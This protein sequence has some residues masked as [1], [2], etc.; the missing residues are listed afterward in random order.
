[1][2]HLTHLETRCKHLQKKRLQLEK[3]KA[4]GSTTGDLEESISDDEYRLRMQ[5]ETGDYNLDAFLLDV[6][7]EAEARGRKQAIKAVR[8][9]G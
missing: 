9:L 6:I 1:M 5:L 2:S 4:A 3:R 7:A 8:A